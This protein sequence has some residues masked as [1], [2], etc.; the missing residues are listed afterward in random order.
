MLV[1]TF[2]LL[3]D[4]ETC[5]QSENP[6]KVGTDAFVKYDEYKSAATVP[7]VKKGGSKAADFRHDWDRG[8]LYLRREDGFFVNRADSFFRR[9][10]V[11]P[12]WASTQRRSDSQRWRPSNAKKWRCLRSTAARLWLRRSHVSKNRKLRTLGTA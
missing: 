4:V 11:Q 1:P 7:D 10:V 2:P 12:P 5:Y 8:F 3:D 9:K 6:K